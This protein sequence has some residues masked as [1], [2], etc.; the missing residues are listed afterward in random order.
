M[1]ESNTEEEVSKLQGRKWKT[2]AMV[3]PEPAGIVFTDDL[4]H[5]SVPVKR[6]HDQDSSHRRK[7]LVRGLLTVLEAY[8]IIIRAGSRHMPTI[9][10]THAL[11]YASTSYSCQEQVQI[12]FQSEM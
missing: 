10:G 6:H 4:S 5:C 3:P 1:A 11:A 7:H 12:W 2:P 8:F 9:A